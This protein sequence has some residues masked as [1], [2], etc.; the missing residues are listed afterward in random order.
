MSDSSQVSLKRAEGVALAALVLQTIVTVVML[1]AARI[2]DS[3]AVQAE[4]LHLL[5]GI[6]LWLVILLHQRMK[7]QAEEET[8][9]LEELHRER[10][11]SGRSSRLFEEG[12][13]D[14]MAARGR[15]EKFEKYFNPIFA[16]VYGLALI[17]AAVL[18]FTGGQLFSGGDQ[19]K[20]D[21]AA[22]VA[23]LCGGAVL[24]LFMMAKYAVGMSSQKAW[25]PLR[26]GAS[27]AGG[28]AGMLLLVALGLLFASRT[29]FIVDTI[30]AWVVVVVMVLLGIE[31]ILT[32]VMDIYRPRVRGQEPRVAYDSRLLGMFIQREGLF[33]TVAET[34][35]YQFGFRVSD[36]WF[37]R[38]M[39]K[40]IAPLLLFQILTFWLLT[41]MV[42]VPPGQAGFITR[43]GRLVEVSDASTTEPGWGK[44][45]HPSGLHFKWPW[46]I[47]NVRLVEVDPV[48]TLNL[49]DTYDE[50]IEDEMIRNRVLWAEVHSPDPYFWLVSMEG[51]EAK[52]IYLSGRVKV[53][54]NVKNP[55]RY[56]YR[57]DNPD[58]MVEAVSYRV[59]IQYMA[60]SDMLKLLTS[61]LE[62]ASR[63]IQD[64]IQAK[65]DRMELGVNV[66]YV[67]LAQLHPPRGSEAEGDPEAGN[68]AT[69]F[70]RVASASFERRKIKMEAEIEADSIAKEAAVHVTD[71]ES[72]AKTYA[73]RQG[74]VPEAEANR[75]LAR[76]DA[77][78]AAPEY[79]PMNELLRAM[80]A[81]FA[82]NRKVVVSKEAAG[83]H[84]TIIDLKEVLDIFGGLT[85]MTE[86]GG[87]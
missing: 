72:E 8:L 60:H 59:L 38:F 58:K 3:T 32:M 5:I 81:S 43:W 16:V 46:P 71:L 30:V 10:E 82:E 57:W 51:V 86:S 62:E 85:D 65:C 69:A 17:G 13:L 53:Q 45:A 73:A 44:Y 20:N 14:P 39:E 11:A 79:Y 22:L 6:P 15:L 33:H 36:T 66:L 31:S 87:E 25:R 68:V 37:Y 74:L 7:R 35:N 52:A 63:E 75:F 19:V 48:R 49:G 42:M 80:Q 18:V 23:A 78:R 54:Y 27:F 64:S 83:S 77:Y 84:V 47:G 12:H 40:A 24:L 56:A 34:L 29:I 76:V 26:S 21:S 61:N 2:T 70:E 9:E 50:E 4:S 55:Y 1:V 41:S 67:S 28:N